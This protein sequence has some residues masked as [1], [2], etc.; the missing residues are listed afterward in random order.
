MTFDARVVDISETDEIFE[1]EQKRLETS[2]E[3][4]QLRMILSWQAPW[5]KESLE[6]YLPKGW[7]FAV[8]QN[9]QL[10]G[11]FLA[12]PVLFFRQMTQTLWLEHV[13]FDSKEAGDYLL[14]L[15]F[16][17]AREKHIQSVLVSPQEELI[18]LLQA[19]GAKPVSDLYYEFQSTKIAK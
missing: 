6:F 16:K 5:R 4:E 14:E 17:T 3:D 19:R 13:T 2:V 11:Y 18:P 7:C 12:Q 10:V 9:E 15:A 1:F 8:R